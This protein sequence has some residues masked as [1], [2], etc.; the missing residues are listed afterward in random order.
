M[1]ENKENSER[2]GNRHM[3]IMV[4]GICAVC[5]LGCLVW[6][7]F[8]IGGN[9]RTEEE[10]SAIRQEYVLEVSGETPG[11]KETLEAEPSEGEVMAENLVP[12]VS[13]ALTAQP[14]NLL[15]YD[16]PDKTVDIAALQENENEDIYAW[17]TVPGTLIDYPILQHPDQ[18]DYYLNHNMD[19]SSGYP[20][21]I[22]SQFLNS[23]EF[24]DPNTVLY[25]HNMKNG[26][27]FAGLH[28]YEDSQFL[29]E[30]PYIYIFT[31][32]YVRVYHIF[33]AYEYD[34]RHLLLTADMED[35]AVFAKYLE[36]V[37]TLNGIRD[38]FLE[39][40]PVSME[41]KVLTLETC[42]ANKPDR[43]Y[44]V[45][46]VLEAEGEWPEGASEVLQGHCDAIP[47]EETMAE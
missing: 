28:F 10:L 26:S 32:G 13:L 43:R 42:I 5:F 3:W 12:E 20:G 16:I 45:Q 44:I 17:I 22:Y 37:Q 18:L 7:V 34:N 33:G 23:L 9:H 29:E 35:P 25:G 41:D 4:A 11:Q 14:S 30:N 31:Q 39:D 21:C 19:N 40:V 1:R 8:Y 46:A 47:Q 27:M 15:V 24:D 2:Q 36:E 38:N 6:L